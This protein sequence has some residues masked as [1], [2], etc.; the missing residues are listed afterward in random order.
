[1]AE[2]ACTVL[3]IVRTINVINERAHDDSPIPPLPQSSFVTFRKF[4]GPA[5]V[6][7]FARILS[8]ANFDVYRESEIW[9]RSD[10]NAGGVAA[11]AVAREPGEQ[12]AR[13]RASLNERGAKLNFSRKEAE[14]PTGEVK[15]R[16]PILA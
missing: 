6:R 4:C 14:S 7:C 3:S 5:Q 15:R 8:L 2:Y 9:S 11:G 16:S 12:R 13:A 1:M 10:K